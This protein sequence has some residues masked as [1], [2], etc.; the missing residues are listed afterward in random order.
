MSIK[1]W[2]I[3]GSA[4]GFGYEIARAALAQGERVIATAR[5]PSRLA[6][7]IE[8]S[9]GR[10]CALELDVNDPVSVR[11]AIEA[12]ER[13]SGGIDVLVNSAGYG[14]TAAIEES[15]DAEVRSLI[16]THFFG[17][18]A[19]I[20]GVLPK[21][22]ARRSGH[23]INL[24]SIA[25][26]R[27]VPGAGIYAAAKFAIEGMSEGL[28][29]ELAPLG[30]RVTIVEPGPFQN[31][32]FTASRRYAERRIKDYDNT[33]GVARARVSAPGRRLAGDPVRAAKTI[34][35]IVDHPK[36]PLRLP[37][38]RSAYEGILETLRA[39]IAEVEQWKDV[40]I[41]ADFPTGL[42]QS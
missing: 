2:L 30:I 24:S 36:P 39:R 10:L 5:D 7:L 19:M 15:T 21:M 18:L 8:G 12:A 4:T 9:D 33:V 27:A 29:A 34:V 40:I 23:I 6:P 20:R 37:L 35:G 14:F 17:A 25:G 26:I 3:T 1:A 28:A 11:T 42:G 16:E 22:R 38:G 41:D 13:W 32:S 31:N